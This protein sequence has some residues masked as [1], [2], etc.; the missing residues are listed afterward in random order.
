MTRTAFCL[1]VQSGLCPSWQDCPIEFQPIPA[2]P[3]MPAMP[4]QFPHSHHSCSTACCGIA[5]AQGRLTIRGRSAR[6]RCA[7][8]VWMA[9]KDLHDR[10]QPV[11]P[12]HDVPNIPCTTGSPSGQVGDRVAYSHGETT[13]AVGPSLRY[14]HLKSLFSLSYKL[15]DSLL[16]AGSIY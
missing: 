4:S 6:M 2:G 7:V 15:A 16:G 9:S 10:L 14:A 5:H 12:L 11:F 8:E 13:S 1:N 3:R